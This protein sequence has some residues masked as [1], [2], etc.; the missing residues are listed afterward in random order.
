MISSTMI[1]CGYVARLHGQVGQRVDRIRASISRST[2]LGIGGLQQRPVGAALD[3]L[4]QHSK[5]AFSQI[6][7]PFSPISCAGF[8][9][10]YR[11]RRRLPAPAD[12]RPAV[13]R[14]RAPRRR[15][16]TVSPRLSKIS[17]IVMPAA[18][19]ISVSASTKGN[20][21]SRGKLA[22]DRR[23]AGAH[24]ADEHH[25]T[26]AERIHNRRFHGGIFRRRFAAWHR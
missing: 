8:G 1:S 3:A 19:S 11:R 2:C 25:R 20:S 9:I 13:A 10:Q 21:K 24:H 6:E 14:S 17:G 16:I 26:A 4:E 18:L 15:E 23:F 5:S 7:T 22:T 12:R